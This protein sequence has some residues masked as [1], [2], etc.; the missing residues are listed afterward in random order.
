MRAARA[1]NAQFSKFVGQKIH[2]NKS[3][4]KCSPGHEYVIFMKSKTRMRAA[5]A[6]RARKVR[7]FQSLWDK[8]FMRTK[9]VG[10]VLPVTNM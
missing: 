5:R 8:K 4:W 6:Q 2:E 10:N 9:V 7:N 3:C 1:K